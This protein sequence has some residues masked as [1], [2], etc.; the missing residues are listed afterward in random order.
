VV[1]W[2]EL[3]YSKSHK[4]RTL[5]G[6]LENQIEFEEELHSADPGAWSGKT[7][8][9]PIGG[10]EYCDRIYVNVTPGEGYGG[11]VAWKMGLPQAW[12]HR[13][14]QDSSALVAP[15]LH[16]AF[17]PSPK[18]RSASG[19]WN[20]LEDSNRNVERPSRKGT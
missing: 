18:G 10:F 5:E 8:L 4:Y 3:F 2:I 12:K 15:S 9:L 17:T 1:S 14:H 11:V 19:H 6:W 7:S 13:L 20:R 16:E